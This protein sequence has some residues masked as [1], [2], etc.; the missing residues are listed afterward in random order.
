M[1][2][3]ILES[4]TFEESDEGWRGL[5]QVQL[6]RSR[7]GVRRRPLGIATVTDAESGPRAL[8][9]SGVSQWL[10]RMST[11]AVPASETPSVWPHTGQR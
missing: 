2:E 4:S 3:E 7:S 11:E 9:S 6:A 8:T 5:R 10:Q 1:G